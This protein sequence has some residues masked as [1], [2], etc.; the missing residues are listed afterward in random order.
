MLR[1]S[2][3]YFYLICILITALTACGGGGGGGTTAD[4]ATTT[5]SG[6]VEA[7]SMAVVRYEDK[8]TLRM[9]AS[10]FIS[11]LHAAVTGL[12]SVPDATVEL[13]RINEDGSQNGAVIATT[14]TNADGSY[15][16]DFEGTLTG[17][18][19]VQVTSDSGT[20][21]RSLVVSDVAD[22]NPVTEYVMQQVLE[23]IQ[24]N[25]HITLDSITEAAVEE[26]TILVEGLD[27]VFT[28]SET[29]E[30]IATIIDT[31]ASSGGVDVSTEVSN[32]LYTVDL[33]GLTP[34]SVI[35]SSDCINGAVGG[36]EY[37]FSST[38]M[39]L[40]GSDSFNSNGDGV[41]SVGAEE[42]FT[43]THA[44]VQ[45]IG[46]IP[47]NCGSDNICTYDDLNKV[48]TGVDGDN[49]DFT[50]T[51]TH[52][53]GSNILTYVKSATDGNGTTIYSEIIALVANDNPPN[54]VAYDCSYESSWNDIAGE[55]AIFN[56]Y[57]EFLQVVDACGGA[58]MI[59][60]ADILG[61]WTATYTFGNDTET[62]ELVFS[63]DQTLSYNF[64]L[65][66]VFE[67]SLPMTW[68]L[69][70]NLVTITAVDFFDVIAFTPNGIKAYTEEAGWSSNPN[71]DTLDG[72]A[73]GEIWTPEY[74]KQQ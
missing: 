41:C 68:S 1:T 56:S 32:G 47:F 48:I 10:L 57:T 28:G 33:N 6:V 18:M 66:G 2:R 25:D 65:N 50:S 54:N 61:T 36:W 26:I 38:G 5:V 34:V 19:V 55:P 64:Y 42:S 45:E 73:E 63:A 69:A 22:I 39:T 35:T 72:N 17:D 58:Q 4:P 20:P 37:T 67:G 29:I 51:Y 60:E 16:L 27:I 59:T 53:P 40:T 12:V 70:N 44:E 71:L 49:R 9:I 52:V 14:T 46:D 31:A 7:P 3:I 15:S 11:D 74:V 8:G 23:S 13:I 21:M 30:E 62:D 24:N 43:L